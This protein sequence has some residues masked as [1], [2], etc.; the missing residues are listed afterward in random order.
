MLIN[1]YDGTMIMIG[2]AHLKDT[3]FAIHLTK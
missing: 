1:D 2:K 3:E